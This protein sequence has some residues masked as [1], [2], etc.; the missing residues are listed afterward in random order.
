MGHERDCSPTELAARIGAALRRRNAPEP[1]QPYGLGDLTIDYAELRVTPAGRPVQ[2]T[3]NKCRTLAELSTYAGRVLT[4]EHLQRR[5]WGLEDDANVRPMRT[6]IG[7]LC[8]KLGYDAEMPTYMFH[9]APCWLPDGQGRQ[10]GTG[11]AVTALASSEAQR[12]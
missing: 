5:V 9:R 12:R 11:D 4:Y 2:L 6:V 8:R 10:T 1:S 7:S 3:A